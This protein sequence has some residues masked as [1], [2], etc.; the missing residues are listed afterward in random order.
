M[1]TRVDHRALFE[2]HWPAMRHAAETGGSR[3]VI[4][5][6]EALDPD[7]RRW[8][9]LLARQGLV[10]RDWAGKDVDTP[11]EVA[12]AGIFEILR[13]TEGTTDEAERR[14]LLDAANA[15]SYDLACDLADCWPGDDLPRTRAHFKAGRAAADDC[16][17][18][19]TE[20]GKGPALLS[21]A[22]WVRGMHRLSLGHAAG[23][24]GDFERALSLAK[25]AA[26]AGED[27][28][29]FRVVL[30]GGYA[31]IALLAAGEPAGA[32]RYADALAAFA[33]QEDDDARYGIA[34]LEKVLAR[35]GAKR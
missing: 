34:Q 29:A 10:L 6:I 18:W 1:A 9:Y 30:A 4:E 7:G 35:Y 11:A 13:Q 26:G 19:R 32:R 22:Y 8:L 20:L 14:S 5:R 17:R 27:G 15:M 31:G 24:V 2:E 28:A 16:V 12:R 25:Q 21:D 23:A 3:A 33:A